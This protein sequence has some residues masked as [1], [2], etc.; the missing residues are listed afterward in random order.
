M[1]D[2]AWINNPYPNAEPRRASITGAAPGEPPFPG[3]LDA[4]DGPNRHGIASVHVSSKMQKGN[5]EQEVVLGAGADD[6]EEELREDGTDRHDAHGRMG[7]LL[8]I[9]GLSDRRHRMA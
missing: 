2:V 3:I 6:E 5:E 4:D 8:R 1:H 7:K 9:P